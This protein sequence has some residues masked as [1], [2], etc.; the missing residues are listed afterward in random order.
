MHFPTLAWAML[1]MPRFGDYTRLS[2]DEEELW[3]K[4]L[5]HVLGVAMADKDA[6]IADMQRQLSR[7]AVE[8]ALKDVEI[9][10]LAHQLDQAMDTIKTLKEGK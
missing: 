9:K 4:N 10:R 1:W 6:Q 2:K 3:T 5:D 7:I 8:S